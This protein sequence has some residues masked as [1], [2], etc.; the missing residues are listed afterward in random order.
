M[1]AHARAVPSYVLKALALAHPDDPDVLESERAWQRA[2]LP[3]AFTDFVYPR[4]EPDTWAEPLPAADAVPCARR[5]G[6]R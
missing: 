4:A 1:A 5:G 2:H 6:M 3:E